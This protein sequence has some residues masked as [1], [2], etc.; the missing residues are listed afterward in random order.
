MGLKTWEFLGSYTTN[1]DFPQ[2]AVISY[3]CVLRA[4][5]SLVTH[6]VY[7]KKSPL[8]PQAE[9][10][11]TA[12][13]KARQLKALHSDELLPKD[14]T[15]LGTEHSD[16]QACGGHLL[17]KPLHCPLDCPLPGTWIFIQ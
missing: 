1:K 11:Q 15:K 17:Y 9:N 3:F 16:S 13:E 4:W 14:P 5:Q 7:Q 12:L 8:Q 10:R 6:L 2:P